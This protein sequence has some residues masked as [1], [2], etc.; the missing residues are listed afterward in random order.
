MGPKWK[1][2]MK[3]CAMLKVIKWGQMVTAIVPFKTPQTP[4]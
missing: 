4:K 1:E 3:D 2:V